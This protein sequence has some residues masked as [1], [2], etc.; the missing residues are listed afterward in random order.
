MIK[1]IYRLSVL[2]HYA[3]KIRWAQSGMEQHTDEMISD[4]MSNYSK[5]E[6]EMY[7][8]M[9]D[10]AACNIADLM[11]MKEFIKNDENKR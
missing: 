5:R 1:N 3:K 7:K 4:N 2:W 11:T 8:K 6:Y 9:R 10:R